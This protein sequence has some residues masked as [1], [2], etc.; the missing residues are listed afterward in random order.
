[1]PSPPLIP[2]AH[3]SDGAAGGWVA[4]CST[5]AAD[6]EKVTINYAGTVGLFEYRGVC[7]LWYAGFAVRRTLGLTE[8]GAGSMAQNLLRP[9]RRNWSFQAQNPP[10]QFFGFFRANGVGGHR[11]RTPDTTAALDYLLTQ[12]VHYVLTCI[13]LGHILEGWTN[14]FTVDAVATEAILALGERFIGARRADE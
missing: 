8:L 1:M 13:F 11:H 5:R 2:I 12:L 7:L 14:N 3:G 10:D 9:G 4:A 6:R